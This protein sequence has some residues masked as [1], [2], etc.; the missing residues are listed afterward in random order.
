MDDINNRPAWQQSLFFSSKPEQPS[1]SVVDL[2]KLEVFQRP[3]TEPT[4]LLKRECLLNRTVCCNSLVLAFS[5]IR[6]NKIAN[7]KVISHKGV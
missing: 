4:R 6:N 2:G 3:A 7:L 1:L 5:K